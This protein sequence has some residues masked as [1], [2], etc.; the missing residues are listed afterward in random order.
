MGE[1][2]KSTKI[3]SFWKSTKLWQNWQ[4]SLEYKGDTYSNVIKGQE[5]IDYWPAK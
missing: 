1:L 2:K 5:I 4:I 3:G